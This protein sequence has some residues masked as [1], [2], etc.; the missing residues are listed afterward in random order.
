MLAMLICAISRS[1][2][3]V[4]RTKRK[5]LTTCRNTGPKACRTKRVNW[6]E[7]SAKIHMIKP[8]MDICGAIIKSM[9]MVRPRFSAMFT[10]VA[11]ELIE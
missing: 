10:G 2:I 9:P 11:D 7:Q 1:C 3:R 8:S 4:L 6:V 5:M